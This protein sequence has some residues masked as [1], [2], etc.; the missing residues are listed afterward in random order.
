MKKCC[1]LDG[2]M[3]LLFTK[4]KLISTQALR[5]TFDMGLLFL[6]HSNLNQSLFVDWF[7]VDYF[8]APAAGRRHQIKDLDIS[9]AGDLDCI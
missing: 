1:G 8:S 2:L 9:H 5:L 6:Q 3:L 4:E 7:F